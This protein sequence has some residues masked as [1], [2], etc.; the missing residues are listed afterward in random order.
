M[1]GPLLR[2]ERLSAAVTPRDREA[3]AQ[4][5]EHPGAADRDLG[6]AGESRLDGQPVLSERTRS[7]SLAARRRFE[8]PCHRRREGGSRGARPDVRKA[9]ASPRTATRRND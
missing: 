4:V 8:A 1:G 7:P 9:N 6:G 5:L 2:E 3:P